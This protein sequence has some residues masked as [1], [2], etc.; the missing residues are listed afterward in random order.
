MQKFTLCRSLLGWNATTQRHSMSHSRSKDSVL[1]LLV[2]C[3]IHCTKISFL[4]SS[5]SSPCP[6]MVWMVVISC[7]GFNSPRQYL[8]KSFRE[9]KSKVCGHS[10]MLVCL[11]KNTCN[12]QF[13]NTI[14]EVFESFNKRFTVKNMKI[15]YIHGYLCYLIPVTIKGQIHTLQEPFIFNFASSLHLIKFWSLQF[16]NQTT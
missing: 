1:G 7:S 2:T 15:F 13:F 5:L 6:M 14:C 11:E 16:T 10:L 4:S 3:R 12:M 8:H 9:R